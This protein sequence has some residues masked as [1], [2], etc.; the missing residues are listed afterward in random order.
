MAQS[1]KIYSWSYFMAYSQGFKVDIKSIIFKITIVNFKLNQKKGGTFCWGEVAE[2][3]LHCYMR[4]GEV[5]NWTWIYAW[6]INSSASEKEN[7]LPF[8][9]SGA[10]T[11]RSEFRNSTNSSSHHQ[12]NNQSNNENLMEF[13]PAKYGENVW[14]KAHKCNVK[15]T[16]RWTDE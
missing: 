9:I 12:H 4:K 10:T 7:S 3:S 1:Q 15:A 8:Q 13:A 11:N 16:H 14:D 6:T 5:L 2:S